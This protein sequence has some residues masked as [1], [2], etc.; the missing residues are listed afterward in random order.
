MKQFKIPVSEMVH[1]WNN[2]SVYVYAESAEA[3]MASIKAG[4]FMTDFEWEDIELEEHLYDTQETIDWDYSMV[5]I[6]D[7]EEVE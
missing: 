1:M 5:D 6:T 4:S 2:C 3:I 7:I